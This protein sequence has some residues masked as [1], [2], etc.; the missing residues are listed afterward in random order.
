[1]TYRLSEKKEIVPLCLSVILI[2][3]L[4]ASA[5]GQKSITNQNPTWRTSRPRL[6]FTAEKLER[7]RQRINKNSTFDEA[8]NKMLEQANRLL[9]QKLFSKEYAESGTGQHGNYNRPSSQIS[10]MAGTL[11][12]AY[13]MTG[14]KQYAKKLRD[15]LIHYA[16][17][18]RWAGLNQ[19]H[20]V[21][22]FQNEIG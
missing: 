5:F 19:P 3:I 1:M 18:N 7:L 20:F 15:A 13:Q 9:K 17:L 8:W 16:D 10:N 6:F 4:T 11:G 14:E 21:H 22:Y 2:T 12:L